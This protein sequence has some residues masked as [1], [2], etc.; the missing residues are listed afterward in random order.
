MAPTLLADDIGPGGT[1][2]FVVLAL[3]VAVIVICWAMYGSLRR[4]KK[5]VADG[6]FGQAERK[7]DAD[8]AGIDLTAAEAATRDPAGSTTPDPAGRDDAGV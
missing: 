1:A 3:I 4:L 7:A 8:A 6:A 2:F 5:S